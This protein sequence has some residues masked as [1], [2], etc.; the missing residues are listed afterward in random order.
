MLC[1]R[2][3]A[4]A[5]GGSLRADDR[6]KAAWFGSCIKA[7]MRHWRSLAMDPRRRS[8]LRRDVDDRK[9]GLSWTLASGLV[10]AGCSGS[11]ASSE[12]APTD[13]NGRPVDASGGQGS[14]DAGAA[15]DAKSFS[16]AAPDATANPMNGSSNTAIA[17][18]ADGGGSMDGPNAVIWTGDA[19]VGGICAASTGLLVDSGDGGDATND[20]CGCSRRPGG[21]PSFQCP[22]GVGEFV[23]ASIGSN[24]GTLDLAGRQG[25]VSGA[26]A[27]IEFP[28]TAFAS[29]TDVTLIETAIPPPHDL[30]DWS[31][32]YRLDP[33]GAALATPATVRLPWSNS[34]E[35]AVGLSVWASSDG[36]CFTRLPDSYTN[37]GFEQA[38]I[39]SLGY[40]IVGTTEAAAATC[41]PATTLPYPEDG[42][43]EG[44]VVPDAEM[45]PSDS[46]SSPDSNCSIVAS[47][48]DQ[49]CAVDSD[50]VAVAQGDVCADSLC[51]CPSQAINQ[52]ALSQYETDV[53][54]RVRNVCDCALLGVPRC[55]A[56]TCQ[57][58][59]STGGG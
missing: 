25:I 30:L 37:A 11:V 55:V 39:E 5:F 29:T 10:L 6:A 48:Y 49:S 31:P 53:G 16:T 26:S 52:R 18:D 23:T 2:D 43:S 41:P 3:A 56:A 57:I 15:T 1:R 44:G 9:R 40:L 35:I 7:D 34:A 54:G 46:G 38:S 51:W 13:P 20:W 17:D 50:C 28:P 32:V 33:L 4:I 36:T 42:S 24:G 22:V 45:S 8:V 47:N 12:S 14:S 27:D 19:A 21:T 59:S 58:A